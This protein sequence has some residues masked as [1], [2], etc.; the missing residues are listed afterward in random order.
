MRFTPL[1]SGLVASLALERRSVERATSVVSVIAPAGWSDARIEAWLDWREALP[2]DMPRLDEGLGPEP[3]PVLDGAIER[4]ARRLAAWG[5]AMGVFAGPNDARVFAQDLSASVLLGLAAPSTGLKDGARI[6][7][8]ADDPAGDIPSAPVESL[9]TPADLVAFDAATEAARTARLADRALS[10][11]SQSLNAV[12]DAVARCEGPTADC[13][14]PAANPALARAALAA[15]RNGADDASI[16]EAIGGRRFSAPDPCPDPAARVVLLGDGADSALA[17]ERAALAGEL[18]LTFDDRTAAAVTD[19]STAAGCSLSIPAIAA[20]SADFTT[21]LEALTRVWT[22]ALEIETACGYAPDGGPARRRHAVRPISV[23]P[24]GLL[25]WRLASGAAPEEAVGVAAL[26]AAIASLTSS[27]L[28]RTLHCALGWT[29]AKDAVLADLVDRRTQLEPTT[30]LTSRAAERL[31][32]AETAARRDGRRHVIID[33]LSLDVE[34]D[35]R[36][37]LGRLSPVEMFQ[38]A[39]GEV[40][41]RLHPAFA[42]AIANAGGDIDDAE[43]W[44][45]GRRTLVDAPGLGHE[46]LRAL[47]FTDAELLAVETALGAC[48]RLEEAFAPAVL[49]AGFTR[50]VLGLDP[51]ALSPGDILARLAPAAA[52]ETASRHALGHP[53]LSGWPDAPVALASILANLDAA[54]L[55]LC[56]AVER[57]SDLPELSPTPLPPRMTADQVVALIEAARAGGRRAIRL[58]PS[59]ASE[60]R[61][62]L[63]EIEPARRPD[64]TPP[65][66]ETVVE[67]VIERDRIRR[68]LPDRRKGYIQKA[69]VGGHKVYIHTGEYEDGELGEIFIDMHK[70]GAAFRSLMNNFAIAIS[71]GLQYGVPLDEFVDAFVFTRFEPAGRVTGNDRVG[72]A[73]S[74]LDYIFRELGVSYLDRTE[75]ANADAEPLDADGLGSGTADELVPAAR[76]ISK[77]FARGH[78]PDNLV[79]LPF[80]RRAEPQT[81][82]RG[83]GDADACPACGDFTLQQRGGALICDSCGVAPQMRG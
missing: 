9:T 28:A 83:L 24:V 54:S 19:I 10:A 4:W 77:G 59:H 46:A 64:T 80:G 32:D 38:T 21:T 8:V 48:E 63:P 58:I 14:D 50:D 44:L 52:I 43:R 29:D 7:P 22:T 11:L 68:K 51:D 75:L 40:E 12:A 20:L 55:S 78:A 60:P 15:R 1:L 45:L 5:R 18:V 49:D 69:A 66:I 39:D 62:L 53:D 37:G 31:V 13:A 81:I 74:I 17:A 56:R 34:R 76:F 6:H 57:F 35:L 27:E 3:S 36:L 41:R 67:R 33:A 71:I 72:S 42:A 16:L 61:L 82:A 25:D 47:G 79:V 65:P 30:A 26:I 2:S 73:T 70:E 23:A